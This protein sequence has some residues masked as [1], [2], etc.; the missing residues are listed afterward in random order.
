MS[1]PT[2]LDSLT[3]RRRI[4]ARLREQADDVRRLAAGLRDDQLSRRLSPDKWSLKE[5]VCHLH[6]VQQVFEGR[7]QAMLREDAPLIAPYEPEA[8]AEFEKMA[9]RPGLAALAA[10]SSERER[11][12][13]RLE[14]LSAGDW[15]R[16]GRHPEF[17]DYNVQFQVEYMVHHEAHHVYQMFQRR[18]VVNRPA[19]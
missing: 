13:R 14:A 10:F 18:A 2:I 4:L 15:A 16:S 8:D 11:F 1:E 7:V 3:D 9:A 5:L 17:A 6:R 19:E 12:A